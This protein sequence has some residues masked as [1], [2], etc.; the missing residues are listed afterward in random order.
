[1]KNEAIVEIPDSGKVTMMGP[2][3]QLH[4]IAGKGKSRDTWVRTDGGWKS[5]YHEVL[6]SSETVDR[7]PVQ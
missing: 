4:V 6:E 7:K 3:G 5:K 2:D 1:L